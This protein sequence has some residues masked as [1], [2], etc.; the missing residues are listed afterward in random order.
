MEGVTRPGVLIARFAE[1]NAAYIDRGHHLEYNGT[2]LNVRN[3]CLG[4]WW[5]NTMWCVSVGDEQQE[6]STAMIT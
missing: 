6:S 5:H 3:I 2:C 1:G 4:L